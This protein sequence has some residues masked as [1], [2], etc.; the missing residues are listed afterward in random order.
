MWRCEN[1]VDGHRRDV[2]GMDGG[3]LRRDRL[4]GPADSRRLQEHHAV[5]DSGAPSHAADRRGRPDQHYQDVPAH[6]GFPQLVA[7]QKL[8]RIKECGRMDFGD[9]KDDLSIQQKL[10]N[11]N[12]SIGKIDQMLETLLKS[13]IYEKLS[14]KQKV[15]YDLFLAYNLNTLYWLYLRSKNEDPNKN[16]VKNQLNRIKEYMV[17]AKQAHERQ[18]I[19]P[20]IDQQAAERFVKHG[21]GFRKE[22]NNQPPPN[23]KIKFSD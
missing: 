11:F 7:C 14:L 2:F 3:F 1:D 18:T 20:K 13:D 8:R 22:S 19:R 16:D 21:V 17:K 4:P 5:R 23:K 12:N 6:G 10:T 15:D 9:L